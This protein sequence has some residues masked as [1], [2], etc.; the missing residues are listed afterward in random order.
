ML[1]FGKPCLVT[2]GVLSFLLTA[3]LI[4]LAATVLMFCR[5]QRPWALPA[6]FFQ[7]DLSPWFQPG[8][9]AMS[10]VAKRLTVWALKQTGTIKF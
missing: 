10:T 8:T 7:W 5:F 1:Y 4:W 3:A 9:S 6:A 2:T